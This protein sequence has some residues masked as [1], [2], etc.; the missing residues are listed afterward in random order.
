MALFV[1]TIRI[2]CAVDKASL[3]TRRPKAE[4]RRSFAPSARV[5]FVEI[6]WCLPGDGRMFLGV[7]AHGGRRVGFA[8]C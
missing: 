3:R 2:W 7:H 5:G 8:G 6:S 4:L 1:V